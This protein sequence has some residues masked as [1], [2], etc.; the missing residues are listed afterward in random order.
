ML[1]VPEDPRVLELKKVEVH[2]FE[3][4]TMEA[5]Q[6]CA[7][8]ALKEVCY[9]LSERLKGTSFSVLLSTV[10][11]PSRWDTNDRRRIYH[12]GSSCG[13][14]HVNP[15]RCCDDRVGGRSNHVD[16]VNDYVVVTA[17]A[18]LVVIVVALG[19]LGF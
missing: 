10:Y 1:T 4:Y 5:H 11:D 19:L 3:S 17:V 16:Q 13:N 8:W 15:C 18:I 2:C 12:R 6:V 14:N 7:W 9:K